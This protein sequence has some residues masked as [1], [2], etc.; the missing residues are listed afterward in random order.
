MGR[1]TADLVTFLLIRSDQ[2]ARPHGGYREATSKYRRRKMCGDFALGDAMIDLRRGAA[3][4]RV[5]EEGKGRIGS[6][7]WLGWA[8]LGG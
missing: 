5:A 1:R 8:G 4:L 3:Q 7:A 2:R 6:C